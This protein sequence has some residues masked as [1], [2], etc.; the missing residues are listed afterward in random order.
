[1]RSTVA[2]RMMEQMPEDVKIFTDKYA[3]I[4]VRINQ[5][6]KEK[7]FTQKQL[8][9]QMDK[10]PSEISKWLSGEHNFTLRSL[11]K[12]EAELG[13]DIISVPET[14]QFVAATSGKVRFTVYR[15]TAFVSQKT[16]WQEGEVVNKEKF[17]NVS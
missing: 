17:A 5:L 11:A 16:E 7:G 14:R 6:L 10:K 9:E 4:V 13:E 3:A 2:K 15:N 8:A 1:M 12:L